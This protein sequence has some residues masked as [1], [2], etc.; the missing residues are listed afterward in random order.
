MQGRV[1][2]LMN[3]TWRFAGMLAAV[4]V[5]PGLA[6]GDDAKDAEAVSAIVVEISNLQNDTG[7][8][9]AP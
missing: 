7:Q 3:R 4:V 2:V 9:E 8:M 5:A 6:H 1:G